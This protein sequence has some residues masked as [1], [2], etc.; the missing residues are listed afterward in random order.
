M[1]R[2]WGS[3]T[4]HCHFHRKISESFYVVEGSVAIFDGDS[5]IDT[6]PGDWV[7]VSAGGIRGLKNAS[8]ALAN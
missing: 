2:R 7:N 8:G 4:P 3:S 5:W 6:E 1:C